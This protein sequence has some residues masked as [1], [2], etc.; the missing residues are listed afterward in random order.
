M[1]LWQIV[2]GGV[3][4]AGHG[5][6]GPVTEESYKSLSSTTL[7]LSTVPGAALASPSAT[8]PVSAVTTDTPLASVH[9]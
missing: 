5:W 3:L 7:S 9:E 2:A 8:A 4:L 6:L 1:G